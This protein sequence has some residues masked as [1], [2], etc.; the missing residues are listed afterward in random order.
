MS[1]IKNTTKYKLG[2]LIKSFLSFFTERYVY[3]IQFG[4]VEIRLQGGLNFLYFLKGQTLE[5]KFLSSLN[6]TG[7]N[8]YDIGSHVGILTIFFAKSTGDT[9]RVIAFEPNPETYLKMKKN[10]ELNDL[11]NVALFNIGIGKK[12]EKRE[13]FARY[14]YSGSGSMDEHIKT[15]IVS[16]GNTK[17]F[18]V[19]VYCL[20][21]FIDKNKLP[22]ADFIKIDIE[23]MEY[24]ALLGMQETLQRFKPALYIEVHGVNF[25]NKTKNI[26]KIVKFLDMKEYTI[27]H[28][29]SQ[30]YI[31]RN[32]V[33]EANEG[34]IYCE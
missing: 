20:D 33:R 24:N 7:K 27:F 17:K 19:E 4:G 31:D 13:L 34:H 2:A 25:E 32:N 11:N 18:E 26:E 6:L 10:T 1:L 3:K 15:A 28:V 8:C 22:K 29:E 30:K 9:G 14:H 23:G 5:E 16:Q 21:K 12:H